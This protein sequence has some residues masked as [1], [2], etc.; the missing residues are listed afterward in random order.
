[1]YITPVS[2]ATTDDPAELK[3]LLKEAYNRLPENRKGRTRAVD[4]DP[5]GSTYE[6]TEYEW[7]KRIREIL[8]IVWEPSG[9]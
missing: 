8:N 2:T 4:N 5:A 6:F 9:I 7:S 1:M 3:T